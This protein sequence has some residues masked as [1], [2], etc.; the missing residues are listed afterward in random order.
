M[1]VRAIRGPGRLGRHPALQRHVAGTVASWWRGGHDQQTEWKLLAA[2]SA[3]NALKEPC[4]GADAHGQQILW[5]TASTAGSTAGSERGW[6][7][8][9]QQAGEESRA[10]GKAL[11]EANRRHTVKWHWV[12]GPLGHEENERADELARMGMAPFKKNGGASSA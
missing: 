7:N 3:L 4:R 8:G 6:K 5:W 10:C 11:D 1:P 2:I 12:K 9:R